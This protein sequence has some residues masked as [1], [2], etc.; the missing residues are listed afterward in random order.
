MYAGTADTQAAA[1]ES[2]CFVAHSH[3]LEEPGN[4][5]IEPNSTLVTQKN[6]NDFVPPRVEIEYGVK[7]W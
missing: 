4:L 6:G 7:A 2:P 5:K 3:H 1:Q